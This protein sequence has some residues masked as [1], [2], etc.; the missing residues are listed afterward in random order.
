MKMYQKSSNIFAICMQ[1]I[2]NNLKITFVRSSLDSGNKFE[3]ENHLL[4]IAFHFK[5]SPSRFLIFATRKI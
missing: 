4:T 3:L 1:Q 2:N 5:N